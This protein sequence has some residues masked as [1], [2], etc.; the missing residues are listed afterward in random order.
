MK[1]SVKDFAVRAAPLLVG[2]FLYQLINP[3]D[4]DIVVW[5]TAIITSILSGICVFYLLKRLLDK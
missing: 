1:D 4:F 2:I 3:E 5:I